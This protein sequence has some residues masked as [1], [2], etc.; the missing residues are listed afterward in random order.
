MIRVRLP[1]TLAADRTLVVVEP[2]A[3]LGQLLR[4]LDR[5]RPGLAAKLDAEIYNFA[6]NGEVILKDRDAHPL[7]DGDEVEVLT[8]FG[9]G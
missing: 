5:L 3:N 4:A 1:D 2:V 9:G 6:V 8:M 7:A